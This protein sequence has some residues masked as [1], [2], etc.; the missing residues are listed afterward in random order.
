MLTWDPRVDTIVRD[1]LAYLHHTTHRPY[2]SSAIG[3]ARDGGDCLARIRVARLQDPTITTTTECA[4]G[5]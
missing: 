1:R 2:E 5:R 3:R 4:H